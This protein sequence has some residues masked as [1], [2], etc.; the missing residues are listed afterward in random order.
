MKD[1]IAEKA[2]KI[3][4]TMLNV[5]SYKDGTFRVMVSIDINEQKKPL[6]IIGT[7]HPDVEDGQCIAILNPDQEL[8]ERLQAGVG[9]NKGI[10]K[11]IVSK[12]C[13]AMVHLWIDAYKNNKVTVINYYMSRSLNSSKFKVS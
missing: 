13:D 6:M 1:I 8:I 5:T 4:L 2:A 3:F 11:E 7:T 12:K 9:Y 10:L